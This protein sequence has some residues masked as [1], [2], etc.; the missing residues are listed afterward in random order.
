MWDQLES[1]RDN[2]RVLAMREEARFN[3]RRNISLK[4]LRRAGG[5]FAASVVIGVSGWLGVRYYAGW[6]ARTRQ[7]FRAPQTADS[8]TVLIREASTEVG[9]RA[10]IV[11]P[12]GSRVTLNTATA[13]R[14]DFTGQDR[15][16]A[17]LRGEAFFDVAKDRT[18]PFVVSAGGRQ[19]IA[20]GTAFDVRL[21]DQ[22]V[23][24]ALVEGTIRVIA[25]EVDKNDSNINSRRPAPQT[26]EAGTEFVAREDGSV[27][28]Q[29][30]NVARMAN[31]RTGKL[32]FD[33][34]RLSDVVAE[35]N[36]YSREQLVVGDAA[37]NER[38]VSGVFEP[39]TAY[40]FAKAL[41]T[42]GIAK[43]SQVTATKIV[44]SSP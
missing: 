13:V 40:A 6:P 31:W 44:L 10:I 7:S 18:R 26:L 3:A 2:P 17:L 29:H 32:V 34:E 11:L 8:A 24:V 9:E 38:K 42:Y 23:R 12:D 41:E 33:G 37:L 14:A 36:R 28:V 35:M 22:L 15:R 25:A 20:V 21:Q 5:V 39:T 16:V 30:L 43:T 27:Q 4:D 19:V 1:V